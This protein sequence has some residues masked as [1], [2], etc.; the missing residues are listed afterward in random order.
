[1]L[2]PPPAPPR[3]KHKFALVEIVDINKEYLYFAF[4]AA[5]QDETLEEFLEKINVTLE[6][7]P[8]SENCKVTTKFGK[9]NS[10]V[11]RTT[12]S[13]PPN[14]SVHFC[15]GRFGIVGFKQRVAFGQKTLIKLMKDTPTDRDIA[16][17]NIP[18]TII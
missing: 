4:S 10:I 5:D 16:L 18:V 3:S 8:D 1:M 11:T 12:H 14:A 7:N 17:R 15:T 6:R 2:T 9:L 13:P